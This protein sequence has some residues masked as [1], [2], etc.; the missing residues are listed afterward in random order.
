M[1]WFFYNYHPKYPYQKKIWIKIRFLHETNKAILVYR[2]D[3]RVWIPKSQVYKI[4]LKK[5]A[6]KIHIKESTLDD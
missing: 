2:N 6:F 5:G 4:K 1:F 3:K